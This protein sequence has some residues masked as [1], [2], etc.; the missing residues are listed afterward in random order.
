MLLAMMIL[1]M[2]SYTLA[3][4]EIVDISPLD[5]IDFGYT[6]GITIICQ[7]KLDD[8][9]ALYIER[10]NNPIFKFQYSW[11]TRKYYIAYKHRGFD[12]TPITGPK[13]LTTCWKFNPTCE[14]AASYSCTSYAESSEPKIL[15]ARSYISGLQVLNPPIEVGKTSIFRCSAYIAAPFG[16]KD[17]LWFERTLS[18]TKVHEHKIKVLSRD[19]CLTPVVSIYNYTVKHEDFGV[20]NITCFL[21]GKTLTKLLSN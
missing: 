2:A 15:K 19:E 18:G 4:I 3:Y 6:T 14:D 9:N 20:T 12:C 21:D 13:D 17:F 8:L 5:Y 1:M 10:N 11:E 16:I 7:F